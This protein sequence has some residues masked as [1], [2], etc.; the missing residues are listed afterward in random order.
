M[1]VKRKKK[2]SSFDFQPGRVVARKYQVISQLGEG[3]EGEV[4]LLKEIMTGIERAGKVFYPHR[5]IHN[6]AFKFYAKKLHKLRNCPIIIQYHTQETMTVRGI[7][8][9]VLISEYVQ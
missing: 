6:R 8:I 5:N 7:P 2:I 9:T 4:Y 3:W 1:S